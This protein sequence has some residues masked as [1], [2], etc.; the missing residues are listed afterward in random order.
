L[1]ACGCGCFRTSCSY[2]CVL[3]EVIHAFIHA[4]FSS[5]QN[6]ARGVDARTPRWVDCAR[7][8]GPWSL[9]LSSFR[10]IE[11][12]TRRTFCFS[13]CCR[14]ASRQCARA[15]WAFASGARCLRSSILLLSYINDVLF[16][17]SSTR[18][19]CGYAALQSARAQVR[20][21]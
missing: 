5:Y 7:V 3:V 21:R 4:W 9:V 1:H 10:I 15:Y 13:C 6:G 2:A 11:D 17:V 8:C 19:T 20:E 16:P 12:R 18:T 14:I